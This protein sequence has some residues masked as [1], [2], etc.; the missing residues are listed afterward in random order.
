MRW[1]KIDVGFF[2][3]P[4]ALAAGK[5]G[6]ALYLAGLC[7]TVEQLSDGHVPNN[8]LAIIAAQAD[9]KAR[10]A[11]R[12]LVRVGL[13]DEAPDGW[14]IHDFEVFN[15]ASEV[16]RKRVESGRK[17][18]QR[19]QA[20]S[21]Q[22]LKQNG[23]KPD[24][25]ARPKP[26]NLVE[27][28]IEVEV[29]VE[30]SSSSGYSQ[31]LGASADEDEDSQIANSNN[32]AHTVLADLAK[33]DLATRQANVQLPPVGDT[34]R[35]LSEAFTRRS[36]SH[37]E[38]V[39]GLIEQHP[40][41]PKDALVEALCNDSVMGVSRA[42]SGERIGHTYDEQQ[43]AQAAIREANME[44][45]RAERDRPQADAQ[46]VKSVVVAAWERLA[47]PLQGEPDDPR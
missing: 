45:V 31:P 1:A 11:V 30:G 20:N 41:W 19:A 33:R 43:R 27:D 14:A 7:W 16:I 2:R 6:R 22:V 9:V 18:G 35:W 23:S 8:A 28:Y 26:A 42:A 47:H 4:K 25:F 37:G 21:K 46:H 44:R 38:A 17:G 40:E 12:T 36:A 39:V 32:L 15:D 10:P 3:N 13:W 34:T 29:D 5:D 24:D